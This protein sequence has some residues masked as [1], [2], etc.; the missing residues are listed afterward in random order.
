[1][2]A[3]NSNHIISKLKKKKNMYEFEL[4]TFNWTISFVISTILLVFFFFLGLNLI[5][6]YAK[7]DN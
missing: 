4:W 2:N 7:I 6:Q 3:I 1:M 5:V